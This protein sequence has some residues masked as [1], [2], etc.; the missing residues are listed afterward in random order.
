VGGIPT[1]AIPRFCNA[2]QD[3]KRPEDASSIARHNTSGIARRP[4]YS[5]V[6]MLKDTSLVRCMLKYKGLLDIK[7]LWLPRLV[8]APYPLRWFLARYSFSVKPPSFRNFP[9]SWRSSWSSRKFV[10]CIKQTSEFAAVSG[11]PS[12]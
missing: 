2:A 4:G 5:F 12:T 8:G 1:G 10:W 3:K 9:S 11:V 6:G 7:G